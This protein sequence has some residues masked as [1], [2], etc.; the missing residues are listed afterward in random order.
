MNQTTKRIY[1]PTTPE[2][3]RQTLISEIEEIDNWIDEH[4]CEMLR[5]NKY[6]DRYEKLE[7][8]HLSKQKMRN[9]AVTVLASL[10]QARGTRP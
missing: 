4:K 9:F 3:D 1:A 5:K 10:D 2:Q 7:N 8:A 6:S